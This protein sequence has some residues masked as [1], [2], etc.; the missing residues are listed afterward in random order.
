MRQSERR[1]LVPVEDLTSDLNSEADFNMSSAS[2]RN[3]N[4]NQVLVQKNNNNVQLNLNANSGA[5]SDIKTPDFD[6]AFQVNAIKIKSML[7]VTPILDVH[8]YL[9]MLAIDKLYFG[10]VNQMILL[11]FYIQALRFNSFKCYLL[12]QKSAK[13]NCILAC[14]INSC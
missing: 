3:V 7:S 5:D 9:L 14:Y 6:E 11:S 10:K 8:I 1:R 2:Q 13:L 12:F 4:R